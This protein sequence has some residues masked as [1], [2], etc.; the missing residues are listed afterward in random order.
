M[1]LREIKWDK[2]AFANTIINLLVPY[3]AENLISV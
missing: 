3:I 1:I 2:M